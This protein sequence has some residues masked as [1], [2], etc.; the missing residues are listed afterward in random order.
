MSLDETVIGPY[1]MSKTSIACASNALLLFGV[2]KTFVIILL[3]MPQ[4]Y[5]ENESFWYTLVSLAKFMFH[6]FYIVYIHT[7]VYICRK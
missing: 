7:Y 1:F 6:L 4:G 5:Y 2:D 3:L